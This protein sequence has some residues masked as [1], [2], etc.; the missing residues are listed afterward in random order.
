M[1]AVDAMFSDIFR[2]QERN[3]STIRNLV[4]TGNILRPSRPFRQI[5]LLLLRP[6]STVDGVRDSIHAK[7][8][9][10]T[11]KG[12]SCGDKCTLF[13]GRLPHGVRP[14]S[15]RGKLRELF[16]PFGKITSIKVGEPYPVGV[17]VYTNN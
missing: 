12:E 9:E 1:H 14:W 6:Y 2:I 10:D 13:V 7:T 4:R 17:S 3:W 8:A 16:Q 5:Q 15:L 11:S